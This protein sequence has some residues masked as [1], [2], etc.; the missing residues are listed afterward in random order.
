MNRSVLLPS[1]STGI[2][3]MMRGATAFAVM[4]ILAKCLMQDLPVTEVVFLRS[5]LGTLWMFILI[6]RKK[7]SFLGVNRRILFLRGLFGALALWFGFSAIS[8][9]HLAN[10]IFLTQ[11]APVFASILGI[12]FLREHPGARTLACV[13]TAFAGIAILLSPQ[14]NGWDNGGLFGVLSGLCAALAY[15]CV[16]SLRRTDSEYTIIFYFTLISSL[17]TAPAVLPN[18]IWPDLLDWFLI[19][20]VLITSLIGQIRLTRAL[21]HASAHTVLPFGY[22]TPIL[23]AL[24]GWLLWKEK[25]THA[26]ML[27]AS[28]TIGSGVLLY[29]FS[30][31]RSESG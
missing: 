11:T 28:M 21:Q 3:L 18:F 26:E 4:S 14:H 27:G 13:F 24:F 17:I 10:A 19:T 22:L 9:L 31:R 1:T 2:H 25:M 8:T 23:G 30:N 15:L 16:R 7:A 29:R 12:F 20:G 6:R 5:I